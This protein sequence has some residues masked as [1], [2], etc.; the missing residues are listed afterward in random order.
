MS[1]GCGKKSTQLRVTRAQTVIPSQSAQA[2]T[3]QRAHKV[4]TR[5][6]KPPELDRPVHN[7]SMVKR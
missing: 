2:A 3:P 6:P 4:I 1:C 5:E 7:Y